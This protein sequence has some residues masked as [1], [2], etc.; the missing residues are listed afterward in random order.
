MP[1]TES[2]RAK[3]AAEVCLSVGEH[4]LLYPLAPMALMGIQYLKLYLLFKWH[5]TEDTCVGLRE[6]R[7]WG[8]SYTISALLLGSNR[9]VLPYPVSSPP[10]LPNTSKF[11]L[12]A[13]WVSYHGTLL[14]LLPLEQ[15]PSS[16]WCWPSRWHLSPPGHYH[17]P[18]SMFVTVI[19]W[20]VNVQAAWSRRRIGRLIWLVLA[21][22]CHSSLPYI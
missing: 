6:M 12:A 1:T 15:R 10:H 4:R 19:A 13:R 22:T 7:Q 8:F 9:L 2:C 21:R 16:D 11:P 14:L 18:S 5:R 17:V 20:L 3:A